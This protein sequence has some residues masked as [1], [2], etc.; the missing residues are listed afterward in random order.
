MFEFCTHTVPGEPRRVRV[1]ALNST[2]IR[3]EWQP[4]KRDERHGIVRGYHIHFYKVDDR[5]V[6]VGDRH[7]YDTMDRD[8][9]EAVISGLEPDTTY[10][11]TVAAYTRKGD[12]TRSKPAK[13]AKTKGAGK[14]LSVIN[15]SDE[16]DNILIW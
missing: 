14:E 11:F 9:E 13:E 16:V 7:R 5:G 2:A 1:E 4:P 12:G 10:Q 15:T 8:Q 6:P 3:I